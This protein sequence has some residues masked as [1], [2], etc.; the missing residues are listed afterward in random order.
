M[1]THTERKSTFNLTYL[2]IIVLIL[3]I[4]L[5]VIVNRNEENINPLKDKVNLWNGNDL[6]GWVFFLD[7]SIANPD[8]VF[9]VTNN[10]IRIGGQPFGYMRTMEEYGIY[11]LHLEW[12]WP[13]EPGNSGVFLN[14]T[15]DDKRWPMTIECQLMAGNA[16]DMVFLGESDATERVDKSNL[17]MAKYEESTENPPGEWNAYD[18][19]TRN[20]S[21]IVFVNGVLQNV[22]SRP[23]PAKGFIGLQS[24][25]APVEFRN[26]YLLAASNN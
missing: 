17:V 11:D 3:I 25:G 13:E 5:F 8:T 26:V 9:T 14:I 16:G 15:G 23:L 7:D 4:L 12:R 10:V 22:C 18:I 20:D 19:H 6:S 24:E 2:A 1:R 21:I